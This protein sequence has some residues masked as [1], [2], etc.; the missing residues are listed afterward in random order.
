MIFYC[1]SIYMNAWA[2]TLMH[3]HTHLHA[4]ILHRLN[5]HIIP[6]HTYTNIQKHTHM[7]T[8]TYTPTSKLYSEIVMFCQICVLLSVSFFLNIKHE[9]YICLYMLCDILPC[10]VRHHL[11]R[12]DSRST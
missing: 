9:M 5:I 6:S 10:C 3:S 7:R 2:N 12:I 4:C 1:N 8:H 11:R